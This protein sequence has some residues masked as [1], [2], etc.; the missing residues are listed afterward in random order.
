MSAPSSAGTDTPSACFIPVGCDAF[1]ARRRV[2]LQHFSETL[3]GVGSIRAYATVDR[4]TRDND[5]RVANN[6]AAFWAGAATNRWLGVRLNW[7]GTFI[8]LI[9]CLVSLVSAA[10][11]AI[12]VGLVGLVLAYSIRITGHLM[13]LVRN[14]TATEAAMNRCVVGGVRDAAVASRWQR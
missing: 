9:A 6:F 14:F 2:C 3:N 13:W 7:L 10:A 1:F 4:F 12:G 5:A 11:G 8:V